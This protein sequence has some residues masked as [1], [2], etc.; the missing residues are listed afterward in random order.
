[1]GRPPIHDKAMTDA[2][3]Q[4][5]HREKKDAKSAIA[6]GSIADWFEEHRLRPGDLVPFDPADLEPFDLAELVPFDP[7]DFVPFDLSRARHSSTATASA[8]PKEF[9]SSAA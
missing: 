6:E 5:R 9:W 7:A 2:E 4:R 1:M 8:N 3:R